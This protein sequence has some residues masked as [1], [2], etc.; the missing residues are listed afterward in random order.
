MYTIH[1]L[2]NVLDLE[3]FKKNIEKDL[4]IWKK[5]RIFVMLTD[6]GSIEAKINRVK[7]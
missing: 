7:M 4:D 2:G 3:K 5:F 1:G 6:N